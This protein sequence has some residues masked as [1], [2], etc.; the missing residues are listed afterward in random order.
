[1]TTQAMPVEQSPAQ[2]K[3]RRVARADNALTGAWEFLIHAVVQV[4]QLRKPYA[5]IMHL[6]LFW[7]VTIQIVGTAIN[8]MQM[9]LFTP[10]EL[11]GPRGNAYLA[12]EVAM[13]WAGI[14]ILLGVVMAGYR[15]L[16]LRPAALES[17]L[18]DW[19]ALG[20]LALVAVAGFG[21]EGLRLYSTRPAWAAYS[22]LGNAVAAGYGALG[23]TE[24]QVLPLHLVLFWLHTGLG[25]L[26]VASVPFTKLRHLVVIPWNILRRPRRPTGALEPILDIEN[27]ESFGAGHITELPGHQLLALDACVRCGRCEEN[28]PATL[29]G[30]ALSPRKVV[31]GLRDA[32]AD[33][34]IARR[35]S[36]ETEL[37]DGAVPPEVT[38]QCTTCGACLTVCP[39][40]VNPVD[41]LVELRRYQTMS[42]GEVPG[43]V[44]DTLRNIERY[45]NPWGLPVEERR[46]RVLEL[47]VRQVRPGESCEVLLF[48]GCAAS[49]DERNR[50]VAQAMLQ[51]M[52]A[53]GADVAVLASGESCCGEPARRLGHEY[54]FQMLAEENATRF[55]EVS[56]ERIVT[57]CPHCYHT[58]RHEYAQF[59]HRWLV[60]HFT[61]F[62]A[63]RTDGTARGARTTNGRLAYHDSCY[64]GR[65][66]Q[67]YGPPRSL[68]DRAVQGR[69][70]LRR[71]GVTSFCCGGGGGQ[72]WL[73]TD[74]A[75]RINQRRLDEVIAAGVD[76]VVTACPYCLTMFD[77]AVRSRGL[78]DQIRVLDVAEVLAEAQETE[79]LKGTE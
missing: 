39:A 8:L 33:A 14:A 17:R 10:F 48:L 58:L 4:R 22:P 41:S 51:L 74:P 54:L 68:V 9:K 23:L 49:L 29:S 38:W 7:G 61:E 12:Y 43:Q 6:L 31:V 15:R 40:F 53:A 60:Q 46:E 11:S 77:D 16:V 69:V 32:M 62:Y 19:Y 34:L 79:K 76:T 28:C 55:G 50:K 2:P 75:T 37:L 35:S 24:Q 44:A 73:E 13:E 21:V 1:M 18:D 47:G 78:V 5:A 25:L 56:F 64:L 42:T 26:F 45:S 72:M 52:Q 59:G 36:P 57:A 63:A 27:A 30:M 71:H 65:Y 3:S 67:L 20:L 70:E 66:N